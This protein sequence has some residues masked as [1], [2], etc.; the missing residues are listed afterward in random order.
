MRSFS[1][2]SLIEGVAIS[3]CADYFRRKKCIAERTVGKRVRMEYSYINAKVLD[4]AAG[5]VGTALA[6]IFIWEIGRCIGF[7]RSEVNTM[8]E[9]TYKTKKAKIKEEILRNIYYI[10]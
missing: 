1:D 8:S 6:E 10:D 2:K 3:L 9:L 5:I 7:A 4:A